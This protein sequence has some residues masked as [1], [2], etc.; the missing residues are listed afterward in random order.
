MP[1]Y[2]LDDSFDTLKGCWMQRK[3]GGYNWWRS[4]LFGANASEGFL[5]PECGVKQD[6]ISVGHKIFVLECAPYHSRNF[7]K[8]V[9]WKCSSYRTFWMA[10]I[11]WAIDTGR[12]FI[13]RSKQVLNVLAQSQLNVNETNSLRFSSG[14][15]TSLTKRNLWGA[16]YVMSEICDALLSQ[17]SAVSR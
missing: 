6:P 10:L 1:F 9:L 4:I 17:E 2:V 16:E 5:L 8:N 11:S 14:Q 13:V 15:N 7:N 3:E 12:K